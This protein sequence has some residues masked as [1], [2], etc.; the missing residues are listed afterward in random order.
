M[1]SEHFF[2]ICNFYLVFR[3]GIFSFFFVK[4][5]LFLNILCRIY[6]CKVTVHRQDNFVLKS[7]VNTA[8]YRYMCYILFII[9]VHLCL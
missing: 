6:N 1:L 9:H 3:N 4:S 8:I 7:Y 2:C 5:K